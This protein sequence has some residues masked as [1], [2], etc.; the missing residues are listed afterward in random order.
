MNGAFTRI[1][2]PPAIR[3]TLTPIS[4]SAFRVSSNERIGSIAVAANKPADVLSAGSHRMV[5]RTL[6][7]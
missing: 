2:L 4:S 6:K 1:D 5:S 7:F 3:V